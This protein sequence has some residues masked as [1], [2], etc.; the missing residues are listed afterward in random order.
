VDFEQL[1]RETYPR[2]LG[3]ARTL[4]PP[5]E[6]D[7]VVSE[8]FAVAYRRR[9]D[10]PAGAE[11]GW[12]IGVARRLVANRRRGSRRLGALRARLTLQPAAV[13]PDPAE[14]IEGDAPLRAA[15]GRLA[16][17]DREALLLVAWFDLTPAEAAAALGISA[18][19]FRMRLARARRKVVEE[20]DRAPDRKDAP[21]C[22]A[23]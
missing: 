17:L 8:T 2:V 6:V 22:P 19:A 11:L 14:R 9:G 3:Y 4:A 23:R 21:A 12:L 18:P 16:P 1:F 15:V 20:L 5:D 10:I 7:D 13:A